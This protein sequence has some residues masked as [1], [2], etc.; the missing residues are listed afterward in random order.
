MK[1]GM[2]DDQFQLLH[3]LVITPLKQ[4][5]AK[6]FIFGSRVGSKFHQH[7]DVD[8]LFQLP[9]N[10]QLPAGFISQIR[11][12]IEESRFP[13]IVDLVNKTEL[14]SSYHQSVFST[15]VEVE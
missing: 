6:V 8:I 9:A 5:N 15:M 14:A 7:S 3:K 13:F 10:V 4:N 1:F 11:E 2:T 12:N